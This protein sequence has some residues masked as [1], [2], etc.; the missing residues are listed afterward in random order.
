MK[1]T[2]DHLAEM[3]KNLKQQVERRYGKR[4]CN[5][6]LKTISHHD[7]GSTESSNNGSNRQS[8]NSGSGLTETKDTGRASFY[9]V[10]A[11]SSSSSSS[12]LSVMPSKSRVLSSV[13]GIT[14]KKSNAKRESSEHPRVFLNKNGVNG[15]SHASVRSESEDNRNN[16]SVIVVNNNQAH[17]T[18]MNFSRSNSSRP[19]SGQFLITTSTPNHSR[20]PSMTSNRDSL[21]SCE[22]L[23]E[24][25]PP[26]PPKHKDV[27]NLSL[28]SFD[29]DN[30]SR[31]SF[32]SQ[33]N[34][35]HHDITAPPRHYKRRPPPVPP[36]H[37]DGN[38][39][40]PTPP[41][42]PP[43]KPPID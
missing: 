11:D 34:L 19:T 30:V 3:F 36:G 29:E 5:L 39:T 1:A 8:N 21:H 18:Y 24:P 41:K 40:P 4:S 9:S 28:A 17:C 14:R 23:L 15:S 12:L 13:I 6:S 2:Y 27:E 32:N 26:V 38:K 33:D 7:V 43:F 35:D 25:P 37:I 22:G 42:K 10:G 16:A 20:S 31:H